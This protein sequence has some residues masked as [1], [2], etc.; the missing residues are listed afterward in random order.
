IFRGA[1]YQKHRKEFFHSYFGKSF[2]DIG[3]TSKQLSQWKKNFLNK[4]EQ[5]KYKFIISLEGNDVASNLKWA[6][7]SNSL[8]L[9]PKITCETWFME[10]TLKPNYHFALIDNDNLATVIE[11]FIS[12][13]KDALEIINNAHQ[14]VKK[15]LDKKKEFYIG[16]LV[17]TKYF[18]YSGQ[19]DLN[20]DECEREILELIK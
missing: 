12:H 18:Y 11:H 10:G 20:K 2:C 5:M 17:L 3:D 19:L 14:Y 1:V 7:N 6:M 4:K 15:F 16:I 8:V 13:P 9:A